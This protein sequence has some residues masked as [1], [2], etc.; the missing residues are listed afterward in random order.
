MF[1]DLIE[2]I[3][4]GVECFLILLPFQGG[5]SLGIGRQGHFQPAIAPSLGF[6]AVPPSWG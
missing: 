6:V 5:K 2:Q 4:G 1:L 3:H